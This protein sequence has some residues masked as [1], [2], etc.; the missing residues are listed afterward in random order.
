MP[1]NLKHGFLTPKLK[2]QIDHLDEYDSHYQGYLKYQIECK[3]M[4]A[5][6]ELNWLIDND[7]IDKFL[8]GYQLDELR[9]FQAIIYN[10]IGPMEKN[11]YLKL[12]RERH[13]K[14]PNY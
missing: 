13:W 8:S 5:I 7:R 11:K 1:R 6:D 4:R 14:V 12:S 10:E 3:I 2:Y 9:K